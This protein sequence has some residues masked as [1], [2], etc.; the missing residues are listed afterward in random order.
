MGKEVVV[1]IVEFDKEADGQV[2]KA[3]VSRKKRASLI[4]LGV[5]GTAAGAG[6]AYYASKK[7]FWA[8]KTKDEIA[9]N[10][11]ITLE[12]LRDCRP[13]SKFRG[14]R[15]EEE[16]IGIS[17]KIV[18]EAVLCKTMPGCS[19]PVDVYDHITSVFHTDGLKPKENAWMH[20]V[21]DRLPFVKSV[22]RFL[23][24]LRKI[25]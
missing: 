5:V 7:D 15:L 10:L 23:S 21:F 25:R 18:V 8:P 14:A 3:P 6:V 12:W 9:R 16:S 20:M 13:L 4:V 17:E 1:D 11:I 22:G 2:F 24:I 19:D